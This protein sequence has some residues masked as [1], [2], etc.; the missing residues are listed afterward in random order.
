MTKYKKK[1]NFFSVL[2][3]FISVILVCG[4]LLSIFNLI[5]RRNKPIEESPGVPELYGVDLI[6][7]DDVIVSGYY[8]WNDGDNTYYSNGSEQYVL[9]KDS[10]GWEVKTWNYPEGVTGL[11]GVQIWTDGEDIYY[12]SANSQLILNRETSTWE[13]KS[14][15]F[16]IDIGE[17]QGY[18]IWNTEEYTFYSHILD[19]TSY[20]FVL[21][22][23]TSTWIAFE[24]NG[25]NN[26]N[27]TNVWTDGESYYFS[28]S[29]SQ[30][31]LDIKTLTWIE[32]E[33]KNMPYFNGD[34][35]WTDGTH[36]YYSS[37][38]SQEV[39]NK[40]GLIWNPKAW[41]GIGP[42]SAGFDSS[43]GVWTDGENYYLTT[44]NKTYKF[45]YRYLDEE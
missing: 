17:L 22:K 7:S 19:G 41:Y 32:S 8:I 9:N 27:A 6:K 35:I 12:S 30:Y 1:N 5:P 24:W 26:I 38:T 31:V 2:L 40:K 42:F 45:V 15:N 21:D 37:S 39:L 43:T 3:S 29:T 33:F 4:V 13:E 28:K 44:N 25:F 11:G 36:V 10:Y 20:Q 18:R 14:W 23:E 34:V 16:P